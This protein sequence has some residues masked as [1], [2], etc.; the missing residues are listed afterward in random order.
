M[1]PK[2][3]VHRVPGTRPPLRQRLAELVTK[4]L[5]SDSPELATPEALEAAIRRTSRLVANSQAMAFG[6]NPMALMPCFD[7]ADCDVWIHTRAAERREH[8]QFAGLEREAARREVDATTF[9][10]SRLDHFASWHLAQLD[11]PRP[12]EEPEYSEDE[13]RTVVLAALAHQGL[14][15][16]FV[17]QHLVFCRYT[18]GSTTHQPVWLGLVQ[19][20]DVQHLVIVNADTDR[21]LQP[22]DSAPA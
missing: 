14:A 4:A 10:T 15:A 20:D 16:A 2:R 3:Y 21:V 1:R 6:P 22:I 5:T 13:A 7:K 19:Q 11:P 17:G 12:D 18:Y 9:A 8:N